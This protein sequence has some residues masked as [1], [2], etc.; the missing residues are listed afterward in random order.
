M[1]SIFD[2]IINLFEGLIVIGFIYLS[3]IGFKIYKIK[4]Y[5]F[6]SLLLFIAITLYNYFNLSSWACSFLMLSITITYS[7][8]ISSN[9]FS[10]DIY[11]ALVSQLLT[12]CAATVSLAISDMIVIFFNITLSYST[13]VII[14]KI[15]YLIFGILIALAIYKNISSSIEKQPLFAI[16][17]FL[18]II[19]YITIFDSLFLGSTSHSDSYIKLITLILFTFFIYKLFSR[20]IEDQKEKYQMNILFKEQEVKNRNFDQTEKA[21]NEISTL[22]HD[23]KHILQLIKF[24]LDSNNYKKIDEIIDTQL[25][26]ISNTGKIFATGNQS[27]DYILYQNADKLKDI[28]LVCNYFRFYPSKFDK[29]DYFIMIGNIFDNAIENCKPNPNKKIII[30]RGI[31][32]SF[33]YFKI[34][35]SIDKE[36][37]KI[38]PF[39]ATT[40]SDI[41]HHGIGI[42]NVKQI[43]YKYNGSIDFYDDGIMFT[44]IIYFPI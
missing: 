29:I 9:K 43:V 15:I 42:N 25:D 44:C 39:L 18:L 35:N 33:Y 41:R 16:S 34:S 30:N 36:V 20:S 14:S 7:H 23:M 31:K 3:Q 13:V 37:I 6:F 26:T 19:L 28:D 40:K 10:A 2:L 22:K 38:N 4:T 5:F 17:L 21:I 8:I 32:D 24:N 11:I 12:L 27:L 1:I